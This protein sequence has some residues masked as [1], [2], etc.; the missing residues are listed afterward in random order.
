MCSV[1]SVVQIT[2]LHDD[3]DRYKIH[4]THTYMYN[5]YAYT[6]YTTYLCYYVCL[7]CVQLGYNVYG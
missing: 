3:D 5:A 6:H 4:H 7:I 2:Y 1:L